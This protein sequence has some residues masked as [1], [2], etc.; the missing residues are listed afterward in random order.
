MLRAQTDMKLYKCFGF[1]FYADQAQDELAHSI[2]SN[3]ELLCYRYPFDDVAWLYMFLYLQEAHA[4]CFD[5][6]SSHCGFT[7]VRSKE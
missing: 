4:C 7:W 2:N 3:L 1:K 6:T 5:L